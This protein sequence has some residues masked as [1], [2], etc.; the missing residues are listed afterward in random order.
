MSTQTGL[1]ERLFDW[2]IGASAGVRVQP[3]RDESALVAVGAPTT[4]E[5]VGDA[6]DDRDREIEI[7]VL[8][9]TWM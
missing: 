4:D 9:S 5:L 6:R 8:M 2:L 1:L 3:A 7:R